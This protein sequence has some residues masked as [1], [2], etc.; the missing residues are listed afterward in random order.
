MRESVASDIEPV[1]VDVPPEYD[2]QAIAYILGF[3]YS[4]QLPED[5][6]VQVLLD[7]MG[8]SN[9]WGL[10]YLKDL[11]QRELVAH[12]SP[13]TYEDSARCQCFSY[14]F[15]HLYQA[16]SPSFPQ[17]AITPKNTTPECSCRAASN[18]QRR[19]SW[20]W[21]YFNRGVSLGTD[22]LHAV[23]CNGFVGLV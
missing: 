8:L 2:G 5:S 12:L 4:G 17:Y 15:Y 16:L 10:D 3:L 21:I 7:A 20:H 19:M 11:T 13:A 9:Y 14:P 18:T 23:T 1:Q 22:R 6:E